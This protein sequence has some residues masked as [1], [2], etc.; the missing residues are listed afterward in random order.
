MPKTW[1]KVRALR[2]F[3]LSKGSEHYLVFKG[4]IIEVDEK[5]RKQLVDEEGLC[6]IIKNNKKGD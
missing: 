4:E 5:G 3:V 2:N 1:Y 6:E